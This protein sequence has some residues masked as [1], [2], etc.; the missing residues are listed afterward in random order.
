MKEVMNYFEVV[1]MDTAPVGL[2]SDATNLGRFA[3]CTIYIIRQKQTVRKQLGFIEELYASKKLPNLCV[4]IND[5]KAEGGYYGG[6]YG[7]G[8]GYYGG[9][10]SSGGYFEDEV[11]RKKGNVFSRFF[12]RFGKK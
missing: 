7:S 5:M 11:S 2:V 10:N 1:I 12:A 9:Y 6:Y 8:Y 4:L 3:D